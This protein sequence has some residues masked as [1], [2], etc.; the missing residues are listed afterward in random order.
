MAMKREILQIRISDAEKQ[1]FELAAALSG[2]SLS[3]WV[4]ERLRLTSIREL[5]SVGR[6]APFVD[7]I[8]LGGPDD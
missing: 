4:R 7:S 3:S 1:G 5:E 6:R 8:P 2:I